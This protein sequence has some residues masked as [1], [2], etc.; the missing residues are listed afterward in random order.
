MA[1]EKAYTKYYILE[2]TPREYK[3]NESRKKTES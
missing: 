2:T 1:L 3:E